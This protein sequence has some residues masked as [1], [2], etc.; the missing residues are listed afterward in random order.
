MTFFLFLCGS[1]FS[2]N[3]VSSV[4]KRYIQLKPRKLHWQI[5][6]NKLTAH[7]YPPVFIISYS[8]S[9]LIKATSCFTE[10]LKSF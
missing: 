1:G 4:S 6:M 8:V 10:E 5:S 3:C 2:I 9:T 7:P